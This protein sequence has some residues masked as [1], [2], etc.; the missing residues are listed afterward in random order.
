MMSQ[1]NGIPSGVKLRTSLN[2][3]LISLSHE[4][5]NKKS[6]LRN[7]TDNYE[8]NE[9]IYIFLPSFIG[10]RGEPSGQFVQPGNFFKRFQF[11][12]VS[13]DIVNHD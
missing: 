8:F 9:A 1:S 10:E 4:N 6:L 7:E 12:S 2:Y 5:K 13:H 3:Y 11:G